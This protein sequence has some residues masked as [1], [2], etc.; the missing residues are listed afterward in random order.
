VKNETRSRLWTSAVLAGLVETLFILRWLYVSQHMHDAEAAFL[1][2]YHFI[3]AQIMLFI[4]PHD[5][6][7]NSVIL[8][9]MFYLG[10]FLIQSCVLT[11]IIYAVFRLLSKRTPQF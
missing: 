1:T 5:D 8:T 2:F 4:I 6:T 7:T 3:A 9:I 10:V 11:G